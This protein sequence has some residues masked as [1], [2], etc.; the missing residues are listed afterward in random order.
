MLKQ[1]H[2]ATCGLTTSCAPLK[3]KANAHIAF[4]P[5]LTEKMKFETDRKNLK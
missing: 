2:L 5:T 3:E 4:L 1:V